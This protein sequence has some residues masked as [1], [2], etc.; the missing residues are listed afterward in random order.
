M[1]SRWTGIRKR[2]KK[3]RRHAG[4][5]RR[6]TRL[7]KVVVV[8]DSGPPC[9][10][11]KQPTQVREHKEIGE[12]QLCSKFYFVRWYLCTNR[13]CR[14]TLIMPEAFKV[15]NFGMRDEIETQDGEQ[16]G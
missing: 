1:R 9:P 3:R 6:T 7:G 12:R 10:R 5:K 4:G 8:N 13:Q 2:R 14:T 11:C 15:W 16:Q